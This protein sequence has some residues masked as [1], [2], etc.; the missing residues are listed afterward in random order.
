MLYGKPL[1]ENPDGRQMAGVPASPS[2]PW[3]PWRAVP[4]NPKPCA[5]PRRTTPCSQAGRFVKGKETL[6]DDSK[7]L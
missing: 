5:A 2:V 4:P 7:P 3:S 1:D 6:I